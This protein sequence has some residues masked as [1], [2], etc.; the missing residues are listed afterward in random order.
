MSVPLQSIEQ[1]EGIKYIWAYGWMPLLC[2]AA[3][4]H[5]F[6]GYMSRVPTL[7]DKKNGVLSF[8]H[9]PTADAI[10]FAFFPPYTYDRHQQLVARMQFGSP[11][12]GKPSIWIIHR[13]H[14]GES[15]AEWFAEG[16]LERLTDKHDP[17]ARALQDK[18][19]LYVMPNVCPDGTWRG[20]IRTN[21]AG[22]NLNRAWADPDE[23]SAPE[24]YHL[25]RMMD[26]RGVDLLLD[27]HG[28]EELP[29]N[30]V[31]GAEGIPGWS[32][33]LNNLQYDFKA[34][35]LRASPDFQ[36]EFGYEM[37]APGQANMGICTN[38]VAQRYDCLALTLEM[39]FKDTAQTPNAQQG[40]SP[41]RSK[42]FGAAVLTAV[43]EM[44]PKLRADNLLA[45]EDMIH[46][47]PK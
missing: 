1:Y 2:C 39:P 7:Y 37:D 21:A 44:L 11:A 17:I 14:P 20:H 45:P 29:Y 13:Q 12:P 31:A 6:V 16:L 5:L 47:K 19:V 8:T 46:D 41:E 42:L 23:D 22:I 24:V 36:T 43:H 25:L 38:Q 3:S 34:A 30:F 10:Q 33:R 4:W 9:T 18:A 40:W 26:E 32:K 28:D 15:M 27:V 35:L